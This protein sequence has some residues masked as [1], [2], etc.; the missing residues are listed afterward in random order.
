MCYSQRLRIEQGVEPVG[1]E[2]E[3]WSRLGK[4]I[5]GWFIIRMKGEGEGEGEG[6]GREKGKRQRR[7]RFFLVF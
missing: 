7:R 4:G 1:R 2:M 3:D 6:K 5:T